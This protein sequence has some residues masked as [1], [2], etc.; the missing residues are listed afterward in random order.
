MHVGGVKRRY[1]SSTTQHLSGLDGNTT[2]EI[3]HRRRG[4]SV[5]G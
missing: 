1:S 5:D 3:K 4:M 2:R